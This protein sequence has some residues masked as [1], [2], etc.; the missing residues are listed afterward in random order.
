ME[1]EIRGEYPTSKK[2]VTIIIRNI[3]LGYTIGCIVFDKNENAIG[4][5]PLQGT[6]GGEIL[7]SYDERLLPYQITVTAKTVNGEELPPTV[8]QLTADG[9]VQDE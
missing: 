1:F 9:L 7:V 5:T 4:S 2:V 8:L 3:P 6:R